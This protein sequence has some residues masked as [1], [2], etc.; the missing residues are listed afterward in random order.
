MEMKKKIAIAAPI[1]GAITLM[2]FLAIQV[3]KKVEHKTINKPSWNTA[4]ASHESVESRIRRQV[5]NHMRLTLTLLATGH[6]SKARQEANDLFSDLKFLSGMYDYSNE[7]TQSFLTSIYV[8]NRD[9][10]PDYER[11]VI[12]RMNLNRILW[13]RADKLFP[14]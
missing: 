7:K 10:L 4:R 11:Q 1:F 8:M 2:A 3:N 14:L 12:C 6:G 13:D 9:S 5:A